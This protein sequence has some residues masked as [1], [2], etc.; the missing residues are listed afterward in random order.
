MSQN[1]DELDT[2]RE[3][4]REW[5]MDEGRKKD[6]KRSIQQYANKK[7]KRQKR[8]RWVVAGT[9]VAA[10]ALFAFVTLGVMNQDDNSQENAAPESSVEEGVETQIS[11]E[12]IVERAEIEGENGQ[13]TI[14]GPV[15]EGYEE[16][17]HTFVTEGS[18]NPDLDFS[19]ETMDDSFIIN[20]SI[21]ELELNRLSE[22]VWY[23]SNGDETASTV[24]DQFETSPDTVEQLSVEIVS[25]EEETIMV[26]GM[27]EQ[28]E[29]TTFELNPY[30]IVYQMDEWLTPHRVEDGVV[31][32]HNNAESVDVAINIR[33]FNDMTVNEALNQLS[34]DDGDFEAEEELA[35]YDTSLEGI[36]YY[37]AGEGFVAGTLGE[38]VVVIDYH[39]PMEA[40]DGFWPRFE[41]LLKTIDVAS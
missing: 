11:P 5:T 32:H 10:V 21:S 1:Y 16:I 18:T 23:V 33:V 27:E 9:S 37:N 4:S 28:A 36:H 39:Y 12:E 24:I 41:R 35:N 26:E 6:M 40:G 17:S 15:S 14:T 19:E 20:V 38:N 25:V 8:Q 3:A 2:M 30:G 31:T 29:V 13:Y 7:Q 34:V 22:V